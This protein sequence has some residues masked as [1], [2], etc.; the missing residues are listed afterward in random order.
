M[1]LILPN[2]L[3]KTEELT[4]LLLEQRCPYE[5]KSVPWSLLLGSDSFIKLH[6][7]TRVSG[8]LIDNRYRPQCLDLEVLKE[9]ASNL[10]KGIVKILDK[11]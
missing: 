5:V 6:P 9:L 2:T 7:W 10:H 11:N 4:K 8:D 1:Q 3:K